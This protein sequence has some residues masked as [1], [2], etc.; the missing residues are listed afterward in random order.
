MNRDAEQEVIRRAYAKRI[1]AAFRVSDRRIEAAFASIKRE[2]FL[3]RG[4]WRALG[5]W[6]RADTNSQS[7]VPLR[8]RG[9]RHHS[10]TPPQ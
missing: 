8:R 10:R 7:R 9:G 3:G 4:P 1:M 2:D 5:T 6:L